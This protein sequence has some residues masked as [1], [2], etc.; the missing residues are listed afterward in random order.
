MVGA[1]QGEGSRIKVPQDEVQHSAGLGDMEL[2][3]WWLT[4]ARGFSVRS[5]SR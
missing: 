3:A 1:S 4:L 2:H 5:K